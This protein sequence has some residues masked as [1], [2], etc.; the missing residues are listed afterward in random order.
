MRQMPVPK[1]LRVNQLSDIAIP[2]DVVNHVNLMEGFS[3]T[4]LKSIVDLRND[5]IISVVNRGYKLVKNEQIVEP[6]INSLERLNIK[7]YI[8]SSHSFVSSNK[9]RLQLT[10]P[11]LV[12]NDSNSA[13][14]LSLFVH[15]SYDQS[16]S[17]KL[18]WGAVRYICTNGMIVKTIIGGFYR[19]HTSGFNFEMV[20]ERFDNASDRIKLLE[21]RIRL[22]E[23]TPAGEQLRKNVE[24]FFPKKVY[25]YVYPAETT[26][27]NNMY[28]IFNLITWYVSHN[29]QLHLRAGYQNKVSKLFGV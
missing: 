29:M 15:N 21:G 9:M 14:H 25:Q 27:Y 23:A 19:R 18:M 1:N 8:D 17:I 11:E 4:K 12:L 20:K 22:L 28:E 24:E 10:F 26:I 5:Q 3:S 7:Y 2:V 6:L 13:I 16:E